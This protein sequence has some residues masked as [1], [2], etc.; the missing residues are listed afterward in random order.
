MHPAIRK[1][2]FAVAGEAIGDESES[3]VSFYAGRS[4]EEFIQHGADQIL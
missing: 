4:L 1:L 2:N 3:L